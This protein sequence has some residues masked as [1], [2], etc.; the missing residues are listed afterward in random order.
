MT[1]A[2]EQVQSPEDSEAE[3]SKKGQGT[4]LG[5]SVIAAGTAVGAGMFSLPV[6]NSG[7]WF[8]VC[9]VLM[10]VVGYIM[11]SAS[12]YIMEVTLHFPKGSNYDSLAKGT[13]GNFGRLI[14]GL[15]VAFLC[16]VL[17]YA[18]I[19]G[20]SSIIT[21]SLSIFGDIHMPSGLA[22]LI[23]AVVLLSIVL[24][25]TKVVDRVTTILIGG[26]LITF[27]MSLSA[28]IGN[29]STANLFPDISLA[30][31]T[32]YAFY[33]IS[34]LV[35]S[36]GL[37]ITV[38]TVTNYLGKDAKRTGKAL[39]Y[40]ILL[41]GAFYFLWMFAV[42]GNLSRDLFP[43]IIAEGGN[44]G[45]IIGALGESGI[46]TNISVALQ[47]FGNMAV[48]TS[49]L[50]VSLSLYDYIADLFKFD[51]S[52]WVGKLQT[53]SIAFVPTIIL[54]I[55]FPNGFIT[56]IGYAGVVLVIFSLLTPII[57][58]R[59]CRQRNPGLFQV[60]GGTTR[61]AMVFGFGIVVFIITAF[62]LTGNLPIFGH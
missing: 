3:P 12:M 32:P 27:L 48:A 1:I 4:I 17:T 59:I 49:F 29:S 10:I 58:V 57:M 30:D 41:A 14:N 62:E 36:F 11:H 50:G 13:I 6:A 31:R 51:T 34:F 9:L 18:Y 7:V 47:I 2:T 37:Q 43:E 42:F 33:T 19:S 52:V 54:A 44:I 20:G 35:A 15:S 61:Q 55:L 28:L 16:Y 38:P 40:A 24:C 21:Y 53:C 23:F 45:S 8:S 60:S 39:V 25:G 56:A 22:S 5:A 46:G 26:M